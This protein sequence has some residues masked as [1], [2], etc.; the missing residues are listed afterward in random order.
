[1]LQAYGSSGVYGKLFDLPVTMRTT[2][3]ASLN[4]YSYFS[5]SNATSTPVAASAG[6]LS[7]TTADYVATGSMTGSTG[8]VAGNAS[9]FISISA[10]GYIDA[11]AEL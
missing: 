7:D 11:S 4:S 1:M 3:T 5:F 10:L 2:P 8:L 6:N 9:N